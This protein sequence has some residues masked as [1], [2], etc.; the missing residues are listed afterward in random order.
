MLAVPVLSLSAD[1]KVRVEIDPALVVTTATRTERLASELPIRTEILTN[2][3]IRRSGAPNLAAALDYLPGVRVESTCQNCGS[4]EVRLL[5]LGA[6]YNQ[7]LFDGVPIFSG[8]ASVYGAEH[9]PAAFIDR[10]EVI[11]GGASTLYGPGAVTGVLNIIPR[12]PDERQI[13]VGAGLEVYD[14]ATGRSGFVLGD[15]VA[16]DRSSAVS[17]FGEYRA[18]GAIDLTGDGFSDITR[19]EFFTTGTHWW[20]YPTERDAVSGNYVFTGEKRRGGNRFDLAPHETQITEMLDHAWH[21]GSISWERSLSSLFSVKGTAAVSHVDRDSYYGGVGGE[22]LPGEDGFDAASYAEEVD[23]AKLL[24]GFSRT[25]RYFLDLIATRQMDEQ[26]LSLGVQYQRDVVFDEKRNDLNQPLRTDG[27]LAARRGEDPILDESYDNWGTFVLHEW[28]PSD[29]WTLVSGLRADYPSLLEKV[30]VSPRIASRYALN[31]SLAWRVS[32]STGF[33]APEVFDEDFHIEILEDPTRTRNAPDLREERSRSVATGFVWTPRPDE[34][35]W[36]ADVEFFHTRIRDT[37]NVPGIVFEDASGNAFKQREN[38]GGAVV[39]GVEANLLHRLNSRWSVENSV[40][41]ADARFDDAQELL[42]D[43]FERRF[44]QVP[45]WSGV[46]QVMYENDE[47]FDLF[48]SVAYLGSVIAVNEV[49]EFV[50]RDT[51]DFVVVDASVSRGF[52]LSGRSRGARLELIAGVRNIFDERQG[53]LSIGPERDAGYVYGP[54]F[55]RTFF[56]SS[57]LQF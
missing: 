51:P 28:D 52:D 50:R 47:L 10:V 15:W 43:V 16:D 45:R 21:R 35:R 2:Q 18:V 11:K 37:F 9:I 33:R 42:E 31:D 22:P 19:K 24:Y 4:T 3:V 32:Y 29:R 12:E 40:S 55:P 56:V 17:A 30:I 1:E 48:L 57:Q 53:D 41:F 39:Q 46:V 44:A 23:E 7:L 38:A 20:A 36:Q 54:R 49:E 26:V 5:G 34:N 8:L 13:I 14:D 6:G 27:S 25:T